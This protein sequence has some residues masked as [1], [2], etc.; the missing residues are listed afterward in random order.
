MLVGI[1]KSVI[2]KSS[3][4]SGHSI[5][6]FFLRY[7]GTLERHCRS[8]WD[9]PTNP[10][11]RTSHLGNTLTSK[12]ALVPLAWPLLLSTPFSASCVEV[13]AWLQAPA[14]EPTVFKS[15]LTCPPHRLWCLSSEILPC[16]LSVALGPNA[17][18]SLPL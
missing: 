13:R 7:R 10:G 17:H 12:G 8:L 1:G 18:H 16:C 4:W 11:A 14:L 6:S 9:I 15:V 3:F 2:L 5:C